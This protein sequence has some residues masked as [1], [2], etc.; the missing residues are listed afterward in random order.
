MEDKTTEMLNLLKDKYGLKVRLSEGVSARLIG[1]VHQIFLTIE[2][3]EEKYHLGDK[4]L[5]DLVTF[6]AKDQL[7]MDFKPSD[8]QELKKQLKAM[9]VEAPLAEPIK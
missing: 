7:G 1:P 6:L 3:E 5:E 9:T 8:M 4:E 2:R